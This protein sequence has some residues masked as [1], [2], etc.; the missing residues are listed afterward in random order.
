MLSSCPIEQIGVTRSGSD[1]F[2]TGANH[3]SVDV[4]SLAKKERIGELSTILDFGGERLAVLPGDFPLTIVGSWDKGVQAYDATSGRALWSRRDIKHVQELCDL[5]TSELLSVGIGT[6]EEGYH[7]VDAVNGK[8]IYTFPRVRKVFPHP[9]Q[10]I[11]LFVTREYLFVSTLTTQPAWKVKLRSFAVL[12]AAFSDDALIYSESAGSVYCVDFFGHELWSCS[13]LPQRHMLELT[14]QEDGEKWLG[15]E[16]D[17]ENGGPKR[18]VEIGPERRPK[19]LLNL[20]ECRQQKFFGDGSYIATSHGKI[21]ST[22]TLSVIWE[23]TR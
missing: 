12:D 23:F 8:T 22:K 17:Y 1:L 13:K 20:G 18:L 14:W 2:A 10:G 16:W 21:I 7:I 5:S 3:C 9:K 6:D 15:I 19:Y 4:W 11:Y